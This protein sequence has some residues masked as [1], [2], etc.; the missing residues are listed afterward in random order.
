[1]KEFSL[2]VKPDLSVCPE[3]YC[4][5]WVPPG[6]FADLSGNV[7]DTFQSAIKS[8]NRVVFAK[9]GC[10]ASFGPCKR[11]TCKSNDIDYYEPANSML[12]RSKLP[13]LFFCDPKSLDEEDKIEYFEMAKQ[14]WGKG[15]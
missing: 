14:L 8:N 1:M 12:E 3:E 10:A 13:E 4:F 5:N 11:A 2:N 6:G 7:Y 15:A 9:G